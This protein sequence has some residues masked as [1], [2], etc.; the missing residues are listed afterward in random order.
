[1]EKEVLDVEADVAAEVP[2]V[3]GR[4]AALEA[5]RGANPDAG[6]VVD[7]DV[8]YD[9][10]LTERSAADERY[11]SLAG[12]NSR[13]AEL[14]A[15]DPK[16]AGVLS[17]LA[18]DSPKSLPYAVA[19]TYGKDFLSLEGDALDDF[20]KGYQEH[21]KELTENR[22]A[23][24]AANKNIEA[25]QGTLAKFAEDNGLSGEETEALHKAVYED[26][27]NLLQG[28][29]PVEFID[30]KW[31]GM[32]YDRD[33]QA[34][35]DAGVTEGKNKTIEARMKQVAEVAPAGGGSAAAAGVQ[36][37]P[38]PKKKGSFFDAFKE[39]K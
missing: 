18:G 17:M 37:R 33:V 9:H 7:D 19:K 2:K 30:Y 22:A 14:T 39:I 8:L 31:K 26:A 25:Y 20:E 32:N 29:I 36:K 15:G 13:L 6:D 3:K 23:V 16:L 34:A 11:N 5:Y 27:I 12:A 38:A 21:L 4:A 24:E 35:A 1:M 10:V 28:V